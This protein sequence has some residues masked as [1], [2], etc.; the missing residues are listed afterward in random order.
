V[1]VNYSGD[2][3]R[4][5]LAAKQKKEEKARKMAE[6]KALKAQ[7][8]DGIPPEV[9]AALDGQDEEEEEGETPAPQA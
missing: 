7:Y 8:P 5:E 9:L 6:R 4:R 2:K 1:R 3:R